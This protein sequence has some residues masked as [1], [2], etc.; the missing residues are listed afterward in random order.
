MRQLQIE[1]IEFLLS[2]NALK[3]GEFTLKSGRISPYFFNLGVFHDGKSLAKL[4]EFYAETLQNSRMPCDMLFGPAYKGIPLVAATSI[5]LAEKFHRNIPYCFNRKEKKSYGDGGAFVGAEL[6][7]NVVMLDDVITA[8]TTVKETVAML[9]ST[10]ATLSGIII[11]FDRQERGS[12]GTLSAIQEAVKSY[13]VPVQ[14][15]ITLSDV[16]QYLTP[17]KNQ[18]AHLVAIENY[19]QQYGIT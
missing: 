19:R 18:K 9:E 17:Q 10:P 5:M 14:S 16:V 1:F 11:A 15:I 6:K 13:H 12:T 4:G 2:C 3:F 8:G 7:G